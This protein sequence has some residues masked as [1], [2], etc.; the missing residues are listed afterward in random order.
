MRVLVDEGDAPA[1]ATKLE[2]TGDP[3]V[4]PQGG[5]TC[6]ERRAD[7]H[8]GDEGAG[9]VQGVVEAGHRKRHLAEQPTLAAQ[10]EA[11]AV[12][13]R[14]GHLHPVVGLGLLPE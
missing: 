8:G 3:C 2:A 7:G 6:F 10:R 1:F 13:A 14:L 12:P 9:R 11:G 5:G 4:A